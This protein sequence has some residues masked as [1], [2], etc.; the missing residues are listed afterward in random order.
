MSWK[1]SAQGE[2]VIVT[3]S[4]HD[5]CPHKQ[6]HAPGSFNL[7]MLICISCFYCH[8]FATMQMRMF[9]TLLTFNLHFIVCIEPVDCSEG[10]SWPWIIHHFWVIWQYP[11]RIKVTL[12]KILIASAVDWMGDVAYIFGGNNL[13]YIQ[14]KSS[15]VSDTCSAEKHL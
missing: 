15:H 2:C 10:G 14:W 3:D 11:W 7:F 4:E 1:I 12:V 6:D 9:G 5:R 13:N 8:I